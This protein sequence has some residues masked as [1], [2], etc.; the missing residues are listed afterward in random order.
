MV[1]PTLT[2]SDTITLLARATNGLE[3]K[4]VG[5][6]LLTII[7]LMSSLLLVLSPP[8]LRFCTDVSQTSAPPSILVGLRWDIDAPGSRTEK[9]PQNPEPSEYLPIFVSGT[10]VIWQTCFSGVRLW[11]Q[12]DHAISLIIHGVFLPLNF[13]AHSVRHSR[14]S[15]SFG[16]FLTHTLALSASVENTILRSIILINMYASTLQGFGPR[17]SGYW[18]V[19]HPFNHVARGQ[20]ILL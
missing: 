11:L 9:Y 5:R 6:E 10:H 19:G 8:L 1:K 16:N 14:S 12:R 7:L 17:S 18:A 3:A 2:H 13:I 15:P 20:S 4:Q